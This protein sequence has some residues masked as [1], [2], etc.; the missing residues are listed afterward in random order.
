[1]SAEKAADLRVLAAL[2][3]AGAIRSAV[4]RAFPLAETA[5][6]VRYLRSGAVRG[7]VVVSVA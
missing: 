6:A 3:E 1:M 5:D 4:D 7:K 2:A